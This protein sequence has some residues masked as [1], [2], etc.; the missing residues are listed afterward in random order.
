MHFTVETRAM[1]DIVCRRFAFIVFA[2][3]LPSNLPSFLEVVC[4]A[5]EVSITALGT[6]V[7]A[8]SGVEGVDEVELEGGEGAIATG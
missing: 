5:C 3:L 6:G 2:K 1:T 4:T 8:D 7:G